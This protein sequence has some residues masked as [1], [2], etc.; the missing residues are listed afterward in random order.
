MMEQQR[1]QTEAKQSKTKHS[2]SNNFLKA[3][4]S[5]G[6]L[7]SIMNQ[8]CNLEMFYPDHQTYFDIEFG[9]DLTLL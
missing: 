6:W 4:Q 7:Y 5:M 9:M 1:I 2:A 8:V 3:A